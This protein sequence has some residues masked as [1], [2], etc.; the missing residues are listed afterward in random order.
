MYGFPCFKVN[1]LIRDPDDLFPFTRQMHFDTIEV[2]VVKSAMLEPVYLE[3]RTQLAV[4]AHQQILVKR[5]R[6][7]LLIIISGF[8]NADVLDQVDPY[9]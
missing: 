1:Q 9:Q 7:F 3:I 5:L 8:L 2:P 6:H 4:E